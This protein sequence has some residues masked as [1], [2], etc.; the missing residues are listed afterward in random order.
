MKTVDGRAQVRYLTN[1]AGLDPPVVRTAPGER[2]AGDQDVYGHTV[3]LRGAA[4][5]AGQICADLC[6][7][8]SEV[9]AGGRAGATRAALGGE[10]LTGILQEPIAH[11]G[12]MCS[13]L[14]ALQAAL[15]D[16]SAVS[17][18]GPRW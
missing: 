5:D 2:G 18:S 3:S 10:E 9:F 17:L 16:P 12:R 11:A 13:E 14:C 6:R 1:Q 15:P 4:I 7:A 8:V